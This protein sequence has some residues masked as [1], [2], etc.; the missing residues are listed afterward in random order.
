MDI[1]QLIDEVEDLIEDASAVPFSKKVM[2]D[3]DEVYDILHEMRQNLPEEI[4]QAAWVT[5]ERERIIAEANREAE[6]IISEAKRESEQV[7]SEAK[8]KFNNLV[9]EHEIVVEAKNRA[10]ALQAKAEQSARTMKMQSISYV[11]DV[12]A[13]TQDRLKNVLS[14]LEENREELRKN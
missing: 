11:D 13:A 7:L 8:A 6:N 1:N 2:V 9:D 5:E 10:Q 12:L 14:V 4:K 3:A